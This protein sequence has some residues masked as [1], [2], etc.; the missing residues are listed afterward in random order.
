MRTGK[1]ESGFGAPQPILRRVV[2]SLASLLQKELEVVYRYNDG[3]NSERQNWMPSPR[4]AMTVTVASL[5]YPF[6]AL[7][8]RRDWLRGNTALCASLA[9]LLQ[10]EFGSGR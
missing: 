4:S 6:S 9:S 5:K 7:V 10:K 2:A 8:R 1:E 3:V